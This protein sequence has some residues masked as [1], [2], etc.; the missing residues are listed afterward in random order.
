M[1]EKIKKIIEA[2][3]P[4]LQS[5]GGDIEFVKYEEKVVYVKLTGGCAHCMH[6]ASTINN[7]VYESIKNEIPEVEQV[8]NLP[9]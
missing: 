2:I 1:E 9:L 6:R 3:R 8:V 4:Y 7:L 5:D